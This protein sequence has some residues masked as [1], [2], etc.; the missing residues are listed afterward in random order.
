M[1]IMERMKGKKAVFQNLV[2]VITSL[3]VLGLMLV[4]CFLIMS[5]VNTNALVTADAN[6]SSSI[7]QVMQAAY[8]IP[9]WIPLIVLVLIG[10]IILSLITAFGGQR[11]P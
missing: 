4:I 11:R 3:V 7:K 2:P 6:A 5:N 1:K 9:G 8:T 10:A